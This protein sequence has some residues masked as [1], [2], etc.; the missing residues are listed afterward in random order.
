MVEVG[1]SFTVGGVDVHI[2]T[3]GKHE[4]VAFFLLMLTA[5][6][7]VLNFALFLEFF[8]FNFTFFFRGFFQGIF[9][10]IFLGIL[11]S[12]LKGPLLGF[13]FD[14][15]ETFVF[16]FSLDIFQLFLLSRTALFIVHSLIKRSLLAG[17][18]SFLPRLLL[19]F[20]C[21]GSLA[22]FSWA[23]CFTRRLAL[24][25]DLR[26]RSSLELL[27]VCNLA[28]SD[29]FWI[30]TLVHSCF[31]RM[32]TDFGLSSSRGTLILH[33]SIG[34]FLLTL[35]LSLRCSF[36]LGSRLF[37]LLLG[38]GFLGF[39]GFLLFNRFLGRLFS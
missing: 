8:V 18:A 7:N 26:I 28:L 3:G 5:L 6:F 24:G 21:L 25:C 37:F 15:L 32:S 27:G 10:G 2:T 4:R 38:C 20:S 23:G 17:L 16:S 30:L 33:R 9:L 1:V 31:T 11:W 39:L 13:F 35:R 14:F 34:F 22:R 36:G 19:R 12:V 29:H